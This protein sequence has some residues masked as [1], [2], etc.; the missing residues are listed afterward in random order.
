MLEQGIATEIYY[1]VSFHNQECF[2]NIIQKPVILSGVEES[3]FPVADFAAD[4]VLAL[5]VYP[6]LSQEQIF[7]VVDK[8][9]EFIKK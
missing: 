4:H 3:L 5:P 8:I 7:Y 6:E 9:N 1:P 2:Q